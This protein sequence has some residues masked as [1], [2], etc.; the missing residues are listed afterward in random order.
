MPAGNQTLLK[1]N[2]QRAIAKYIIEHGPISR[3]DL[4]KKLAISKPTV[5]ANITALLERD[6]LMEI[7]F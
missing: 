3:A 2:N 4:S 6:L 5:S 7:G 1:Q